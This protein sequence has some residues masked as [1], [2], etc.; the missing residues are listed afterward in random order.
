MSMSF[1]YIINNKI[2]ERFIVFYRHM[3]QT[4]GNIF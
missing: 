2:I 3:E 1:R 4:S